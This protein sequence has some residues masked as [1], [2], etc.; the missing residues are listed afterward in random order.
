MKHGVLKT[1]VAPHL[2]TELNTDAEIQ[3]FSSGGD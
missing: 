1:I 3:V 2:I